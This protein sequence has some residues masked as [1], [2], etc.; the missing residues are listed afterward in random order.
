MIPQSIPFAKLSGAG[1]DFICIDNRDGRYDEML[2]SG[3]VASLARAA[4]RRGLSVGADGMIF[5]G[6]TDGNGDGVDTEARFFEPDGAEAELCGNGTGCF[7]CWI[8]ANGWVP[9]REIHI[10]TAAGVARASCTEG[11]RA[12]VCIPAPRDRRAGIEIEVKGEPWTVDYLVTGVPHVIAYVDDVACLDVAHW[13]PGIRHH[14]YFRPRG[15]NA[16]FVE[17]LGE[18]RIA[19]RTFEFGVESETL[20]CGTGAAAAAISAALRHGWPKEYLNGDRPVEVRVR[21]GDTVSIWFTVAA[22]GTI[23][24]VCLE[25][26]VRYIYEG[27]LR[28]E[29]LASAFAGGT[30]SPDDVCAAASGAARGVSR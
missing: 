1:N 9:N 13:G 12:K 22:D 3:A 5:C 24:D 29:L 28:P 25:T 8:V 18:G 17:V 11:G 15:A 26:V 14:E 4:C 27:V 19:V 23:A 10:L 20:A 2:S 21:S 16:N 7:V 30:E 6:R